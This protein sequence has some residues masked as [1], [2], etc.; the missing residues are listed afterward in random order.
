MSKITL[1]VIET[2]KERMNSANVST[3]FCNTLLSIATSLMEDGAEK[4]A[5]SVQHTV[6]N[7]QSKVAKFYAGT[8]AGNKER[9][10]QCDIKTIPG[11]AV[12]EKFAIIANKKKACAFFKLDGVRALYSV[13]VPNPGSADAYDWCM[14]TLVDLVAESVVRKEEY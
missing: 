14:S 8:V 1:N 9:L 3:D 11:T 6:T 5:L 12:W 4:E 7:N 10:V 2:M 13:S